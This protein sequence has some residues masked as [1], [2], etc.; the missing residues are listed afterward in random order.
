MIG[1]PGV[2]WSRVLTGAAGRFAFPGVVLSSRPAVR[3]RLSEVLFVSDMFTGLVEG[4]GIVRSIREDGPGVELLI[5]PP[6]DAVCDDTD[7]V[8]IGES[9]AINGCCLT[10]VGSNDSCWTFQA[11]AE[12]L[13]R[14]NLGELKAGDPVN[15]ER[16]LPANARVGGHFVQGHI[17]DVGRVNAIEQDGEWVNLWFDVPVRLTR[18]MVEKGSIAVDGVSLTLVCVEQQRFS[19][20]LIPHTLEITTLGVRSVG[21]TVNIETDILGKYIEKM[22]HPDST[23][24]VGSDEQT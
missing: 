5:E 20:A 3:L 9:I 7:A 6:S 13:S 21:D 10:L 22:L 15:L 18:Q 12:T 24:T 11:G 4:R 1:R 8:Q 17:D 23:A 2:V 14:T 16:S 19:V